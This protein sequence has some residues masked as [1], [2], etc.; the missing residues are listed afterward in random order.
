M[1]EEVQFFTRHKGCVC[2]P[3]LL[4]GGGGTG[5]QKKQYCAIFQLPRTLCNVTDMV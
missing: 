3:W 1:F 5:L 4:A 2:F